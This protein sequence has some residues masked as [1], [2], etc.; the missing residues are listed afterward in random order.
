MN[1]FGFGPS[2]YD[3]GEILVNVVDF[4]R[5]VSKQLMHNNLSSF[6]IRF[7]SL[8]NAIGVLEIGSMISTDGIQ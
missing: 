4:S 2:M 5:G 1:S 3:H 6:S 8:I 7:T